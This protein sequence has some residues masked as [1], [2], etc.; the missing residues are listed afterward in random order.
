M[1]TM[2]KRGLATALFAGLA[3]GQNPAAPNLAD[4]DYHV[5]GD[6][7]R[8]ILGRQRLRLLQRERERKSMRW[9]QFSFLI[10]NGAPFP[11]PG[12]AFALHYRA[13]GD[14]ASAKK[15]VEWALGNTSGNAGDL[16]QLALVFDWCGPAMTQAQSDRLGAK[17]EA[18]VARPASDVDHQ[19]A[20]ALAA[21]AIADRLKDH[22]EAIL[23]DI[24]LNWWRATI[25]P[26]LETNKP[27]IAREHLYALYEMMHALLDNLKIDLRE[28]APG[29]FKQLGIAHIAGHYPAPYPGP[30]GEYYIPVFLRDGEPD[31]RDATLDRAA[32]FAMV[33]YDNNSQESQFLQGWLLQDRYLLR[34]ELGTPYEF[35]WANPYQPGL[36]YF[37]VP[38]VYHNSS[39]GEVF[40]R[41]S[42]DDDA[43]WIGYFNGRLQIFR[44]GQVQTL[45]AGATAQPV[46][47]ADAVLMSAPAGEVV[48][49]HIDSEAL[50]LMG[51]APRSVYE[52]EVDDEEMRE[53]ETDAGGT[54]VLASP[55]GIE[56]EA[57]LRRKP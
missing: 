25:V 41:T 2:T 48:K 20:R 47:V 42:W 50:F 43:T 16:R 46:R 6:A 31:I 8:V 40:A 27:L 12:F 38:L 28:T 9:D 22:G 37:H 17:I 5:Y 23:R 32:G 21:V 33:A 24:V 10:D 15:A 57:R 51:L 29:Y 18:A 34:S 52:V 49:L 1:R 11:E 56:T 36:S 39:T 45:R 55:A 7:P 54:L 26:S 30:N 13:S 4:E 53:M 3:F 14:V 35:L 44:E 19:S